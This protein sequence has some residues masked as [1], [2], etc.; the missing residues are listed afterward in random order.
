MNLSD[1]ITVS[2]LVFLIFGIV[3]GLKLK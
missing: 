3:I 1:V 2:N